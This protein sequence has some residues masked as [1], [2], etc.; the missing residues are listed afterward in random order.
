MLP[1]PPRLPRQHGAWVMLAIPVLLGVALTRGRA[2]AGWWALPG[3]LLAF[4]GQ[5]ALVQA[6]HAA[7]RSPAAYVRRRLIWGWI[8]AAAGG[9]AFLALLATAPERSRADVLLVAAP[10]A[11]GA[12]AFCIP[13]ALRRGRALWSELLGLAGM[14]L[15][16]PLRAA[17]AGRPIPG[18]PLGAAAVAYAYC[19]SSVTH[20]RT[21]ERRRTAPM[22][23]AA[24]AGAVHVLLFAG[25]ALLVRSGS[26]PSLAA[27]AF[28][29]VAVRVALGL[30]HPPA[31]LRALGKRELWVAASFTLLAVAAFW[32]SGWISA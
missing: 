23:T 2:G 3:L 29:P 24:L 30:L 19:L 7:G 21:W 25:I 9:A 13:S 14:A 4:L 8:Y 27:L 28:L 11:A 17:A 1:L 26:V 22:L 6:V 15:A 12:L 31:D 16:A 32:I 18:P 10:S 5:D 20:V